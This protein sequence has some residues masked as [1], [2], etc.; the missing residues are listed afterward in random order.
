MVG[1][2]QQAHKLIDVCSEVELTIVVDFLNKTQRMED[3]VNERLKIAR[4]LYGI[5]PPN[6]TLE[7]SREE[8]LSKI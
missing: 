5:I 7:E 3:D 4:S 2:R 1:L 6:I 8:R